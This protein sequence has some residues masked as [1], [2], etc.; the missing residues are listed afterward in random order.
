MSR[1]YKHVICADQSHVHLEIARTEYDAMRSGKCDAERSMASLDPQ[2]HATFLLT[3]PNLIGRLQNVKVDL[4]VRF[5][6]C[7]S[8]ALLWL[9]SDL[10]N[11]RACLRTLTFYRSP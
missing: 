8:C 2:T 5:A 11:T 9:Y 3:G 4:I 7:F 6:A 1:K 10:L